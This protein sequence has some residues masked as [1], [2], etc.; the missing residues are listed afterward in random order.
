MEREK[1]AIAQ[2]RKRQAELSEQHSAFIRG[3]QLHTYRQ[4]LPFSVPGS[5]FNSVMMI[6]LL[7]WHQPG[8][9]LNIWAGIMVAV[10]LLGLRSVWLVTRYKTQDRP[11]S[12]EDLARPIMESTIVGVAWALCPIIFLPTSTGYDTTIIVCICGGMLLGAG[13]TMS[14]L[15]GA[16]I[17]FMISMAFGIILGLLRSPAEQGNLLLASVF[18]SFTLVA[19][20][21]TFWNHANFVRN[22]MQ[23]VKLKDQASQLKKKQEVISLLL[24]EFELAASDCLW[25][26]DARHCVVR[27]SDVL[28]ERT[29]FSATQLE[30][31][32]ITR[33]FDT[34]NPG[35]AADFQR[36]RDALEV[37]GEFNDLRLPVKMSGKTIWW[38]ISA[39][40]VY[41][42]AGVFEGYRGVASDVTEKYEAEKQIYNLA[43]FDTLTGLPK[44]VLLLQVLEK[45]VSTL[46]ADAP[47]FALIALD[48]DRFKTINDVFGHTVGDA[49]LRATADRLRET[50]GTQDV[51]ARFGSDGF[52]VLLRSVTDRKAIRVLANRMLHD[53]HQPV[54]IDGAQVQSSI[55]IGFS[56]CPEHSAD[57][58][59]LLK[60]ADIALLASRKAGRNT[61]RA[62]D[63][64]MMYD[65]GEAIAMENDL[66]DALDANEFSLHFQPIFNTR[67]QRIGGFETLIRWNHPTRG[68]VSPEYFVPML[69]QAGM[70][71][72]VGEWIIREA[73][74]EAA[75]WDPSLRISINLSPL[76]ARNRS[77]VT[78]VANALAQ[79]GVD[80]GR[81]DFEI[82]ETALIDN[83]EEILATLKALQGLGVTI[84]LDDFGTGY[85]SLT[86]LQVFPFNKIKIDKSFVQKMGTHGECRA[87]VRSVLSLAK[88]LGMRTTAEGVETQALADALIAEGCSELQ[89]YFFGKG[90]T[91]DQ[92]VEA[93]LLVKH[94]LP[95]PEAT[96]SAP[97]LVGAWQGRFRA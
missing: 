8:P 96:V 5:V 13:F 18:V 95:P 75:T 42:E 69:E 85:S 4:L 92:L 74:R 59:E 62:F 80:P 89:G 32:P 47:G 87:I 19:I 64:G 68:A 35:A 90:Q 72:V 51:V 36:L 11:R 16:A 26:L 50:V 48:L 31:Q 61:V 43:H 93:G 9:A 67:T 60:F 77:I 17:P 79:Y 83:T 88:S 22:W 76:Q 94:D 73:L 27:P 56:L 30:G 28:V 55:S 25:E 2:R 66:R 71:P 29:G 20:R 65:A 52:L 38:R 46:D 86:L 44:R 70:I 49:F 45:A 53:L 34:D 33:F 7:A 12:A 58:S 54:F 3:K 91:P 78:I 14:T 84:S 24:N 81:V 39:K 15:P 41:N 57:P 1:T 63:A 23:Q 40:P 10:A 97:A 82:T 37:N 21:A 6:A